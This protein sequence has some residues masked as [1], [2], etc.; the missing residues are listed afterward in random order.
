MILRLR[1]LL[2]VFPFDDPAMHVIP[3]TE[4]QSL[5]LCVLHLPG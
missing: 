5:A 1:C 3:V 2:I 4:T